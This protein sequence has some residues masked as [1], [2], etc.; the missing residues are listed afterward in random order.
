M[1]DQ[2]VSTSPAGPDSSGVAGAQR[3][4]GIVPRGIHGA[5]NQF[6]QQYQKP[7]EQKLAEIS[8]LAKIDPASAQQQLQQ[9]WTEFLQVSDTVSQSGRNPIGLLIVKQALST[10]SLTDTVS[11]LWEETGGSGGVSGLTDSVS[12][13]VPGIIAQIGKTLWGVL[14]PKPPGTMSGTVPSGTAAGSQ[15]WFDKY[16][17]PYLPAAVST[18]L[19]VW[20]A[21]QAG[22]AAKEAAQIQGEAANRATELHRQI[23]NRSRADQMPWLTTGTN[24]QY[25]LSDLMGLPPS[26]RTMP[27][28]EGVTS[29]LAVAG[30]QPVPP[31]TL[32]TPDLEAMAAKYRRQPIGVA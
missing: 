14:A 25:R 22:G 31:A 17:K 32:Q 7:F 21:A 15:G 8:I 2:F 13:A 4:G 28:A 30:A 26:P 3:T 24:A 27:S 16:V 20:G 9:A 12:A 19:N 1:P 23:Y 6:V 18:A 11:R 5:A 10:P 29:S